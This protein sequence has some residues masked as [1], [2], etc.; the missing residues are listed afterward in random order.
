MLFY[1]LA[2]ILIIILRPSGILGY[3]EF[4]I[5]KIIG[6]LKSKLSRGGAKGAEQ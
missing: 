2:V 5:K 4:S 6:F 3:K 1:G